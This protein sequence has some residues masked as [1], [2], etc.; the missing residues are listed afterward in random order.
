MLKIFL[1]LSMIFMGCGGVKLAPEQQPPQRNVVPW[2]EEAA[3]KN[4]EQDPWAYP[5][6][7]A[8]ATSLEVQSQPLAK[9]E[10][11]L[12]TRDEQEVELKNASEDDRLI[13]F[14]L[15][16]IEEKRLLQE[17]EDKKIETANNEALE[18]ER[19]ISK[20]KENFL[21]LS[22]VRCS[23]CQVYN[24]IDYSKCGNNLSCYML[25]KRGINIPDNE[26]VRRYKKVLSS[27]NV[28][29]RR[30]VNGSFSRTQNCIPRDKA[31]ITSC[32]CEVDE[33]GNV[34]CPC[35]EIEKGISCSCNNEYECSA[36]ITPEHLDKL[37]ADYQSRIHKQ[38]HVAK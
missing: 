3:A 37:E 30:F 26:D 10:A 9:P 23:M 15:K 38:H 27:L 7:N 20:R 14:Y 36:D 28:L 22:G 35:V 33:T 25:R 31:I 6:K 21:K 13:Q 4:K 19:E 17:Q 11:D 34:S 5:V 2:W 1:V 24:L 12:V 16:D 18:E 32:E 29:Y 8:V